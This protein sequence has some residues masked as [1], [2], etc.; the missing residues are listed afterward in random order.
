MLSHKRYQ[1]LVTGIS[2][3]VPDDELLQAITEVIKDVMNYSEDQATKY[4]RA[5]YEKVK[6][7]RRA[8]DTSSW[9]DYQRQYY[10]QHRDEVNQRRRELYA[11]ARQQQ[12]AH[13]E[14]AAT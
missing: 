2:D 13:A 9:N 8:G 10:H 1:Q 5:Y 7:K 11:R 12:A 4:N 6:E 14:D 3:L